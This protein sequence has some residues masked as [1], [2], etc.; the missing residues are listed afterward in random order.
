MEVPASRAATA[1]GSVASLDDF[2][3][4]G[5]GFMLGDMAVVLLFFRLG[6]TTGADVLGIFTG[7]DEA[8]EAA[9]VGRARVTAGC[10]CLAFIDSLAIGIGF[11]LT[12][13]NSDTEFLGEGL[14]DVS[15]EDRRDDL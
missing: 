11:S 9:T 15:G 12:C 7:S 4:R 6:I 3:R 5:I 8:R 2:P 14:R 13:C 10:I 1:G